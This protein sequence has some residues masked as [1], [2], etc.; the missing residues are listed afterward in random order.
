MHLSSCSSRVLRCSSA[1]TSENS[2]VLAFV[3][4]GMALSML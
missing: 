2:R 1:L 4:A 3:G